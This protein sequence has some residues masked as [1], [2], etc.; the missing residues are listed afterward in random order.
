MRKAAIGVVALAVLAGAAYHFTRPKPLRI[1]V[2]LPLTGPDAPAG[3]GMRNA[4]RLAL[5]GH[6]VQGRPL[7]LVE[8]DDASQGQEAEAAAKKIS[9]DETV[10]AALAAYDTTCW[11]AYQATL[12]MPYLAA[13]VTNRE[14]SLVQRSPVE[15]DL[16]PQG[17]LVAQAAVTHAWEQLGAR[18]FAY[19]RD[20]TDWG[21]TMLNQFRSA[22]FPFLKEIATGEELVH[23]GDRDFSRVLGKLAAQKPDYV[24][25]GGGAVQA[26]LFLK[27]LRAAGLKSAFQAATHEPSPDFILAAG[28]DAE[29]AW[30]VFPGGPPQDSAGGKEFLAR[31]AARGYTE[32]AGFFG[33]Y[34]YAAAQVVETAMSRSFLTRPSVDGALRHEKF[35]TAL[36]PVKFIYGGST[37]QKAVVYQVSGGQW[38]P[39]FALDAKAGKVV[40]Y[41]P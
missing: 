2:L 4:I 32:P 7:E 30:A 1:G 16:F 37:Y 5:E 9:A 13:G 12:R 3:A 14:L 6:R 11:F 8:L 28:A 17:T 24:V 19:V 39:A 29:G 41:K 15:F 27:Q 22:L 21:N 34:A 25:F 35:D 31:Y 26:G 18:K 38:Q 10:V 20:E 36:G 23:T 33:L 40:P